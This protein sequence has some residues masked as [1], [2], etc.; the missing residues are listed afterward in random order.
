MV[1]RYLINNLNRRQFGFI[2]PRSIDESKTDHRLASPHLVSFYP[3]I[4]FIKLRFNVRMS[5]RTYY[6]N[7]SF[8]ISSVHSLCTLYDIKE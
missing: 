3:G 1:T 7:R 2:G 8:V 4:S 6:S 5:N